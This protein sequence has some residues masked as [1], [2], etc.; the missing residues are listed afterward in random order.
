MF[1]PQPA[2]FW[3]RHVA[4]GH[5]SQH[6]FLV[7]GRRYRVTREFAD[8]D[9]M[10]HPLGEEFTFLGYAFLPYEDGMSF[11]ISLD[12][13]SEWLLPLQWRAETQGAVLSFLRDYLEPV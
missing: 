2:G 11:F 7:A 8:F 1:G 9:G 12:G 10:L 5:G 6:Q 13:V 4:T 3:S